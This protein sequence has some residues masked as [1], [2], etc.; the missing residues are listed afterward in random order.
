[1]SDGDLVRIPTNPDTPHPLGRALAWHDPRNR[2]FAALPKLLDLPDRS[3]T[4][5]SNDVFDQQGSS[6]TMQSAVG[7][8]RTGPCRAAFKPAWPLYDTEAE[9]HDAYKRSQLV[10]PYPGA[11]PEYEGTSTDAAFKILRADGAIKAWKWLFGFHEVKQW[12]MHFGPVSVGTNWHEEMFYPDEGGFIRPRGEVSGGHAWRLVGF[13]QTR[14]AFRLINSWGTDWGQNGRAWIHE[15]DLGSL[16]DAQ[17]E[18]VTV[19]LG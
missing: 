3:R 5:Y 6:C 9:R 8:C 4:W 18:A 1:M 15:D 11:E 2:S 14:H 17:G 19:E 10:D 13:S 12:V 7:V 16:L